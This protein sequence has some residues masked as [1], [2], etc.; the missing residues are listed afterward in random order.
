MK[1]RIRGYDART[2]EIVIALKLLPKALPL[3]VEVEIK[4]KGDDRNEITSR[5]TNID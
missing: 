5:K 3:D 4:Y 1:G 2:N